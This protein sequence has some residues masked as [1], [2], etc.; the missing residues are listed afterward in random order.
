MKEPLKVP[1]LSELVYMLFW[2]EE[3]FFPF[4][5]AK[6]AINGLKVETLLKK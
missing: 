5:M 1:S 3:Y 6:K 4:L 2:T